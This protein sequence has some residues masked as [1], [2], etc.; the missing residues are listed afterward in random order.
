MSNDVAPGSIAVYG[1]AK[2]RGSIGAAKGTF[3]GSFSADAVNAVDY[4]NVR[5]GAVSTYYSFRAGVNANGY[6]NTQFALPPQRFEALYRISLA[7]QCSIVFDRDCFGGDCSETTYYAGIRFYRHG[8]LLSHIHPLNR[9]GGL[10]P[11][12]F[13]F[14]D[15]RPAHE[16]TVYTFNTTHSKQYENT[17]EKPSSFGGRLSPTGLISVEYRKR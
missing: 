3:S 10:V 4:I 13:S 1:D 6:L 12:T 7:L 9:S 14:F 15:V 8:V 11:Y 17:P 5:D 2:I 16:T